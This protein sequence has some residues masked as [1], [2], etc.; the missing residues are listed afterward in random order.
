MNTLGKDSGDKYDSVKESSELYD[1]LFNLPFR[2]GQVVL[3]IFVWLN[4][5]RRYGAFT[6]VVVLC[7]ERIHN[8]GL[9]VVGLARFRPVSL[10][11][12][13]R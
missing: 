12:S 6:D 2:G 7:L 9:C 10:R 4:R 13:L 3:F 8:N 1:L 11:G 5:R